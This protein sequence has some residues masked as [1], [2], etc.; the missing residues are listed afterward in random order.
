[1]HELII[2]EQ[3]AR[4]YLLSELQQDAPWTVTP[5]A[6]F[7]EHPLENEGRVTVF[8]FNASIGGN[9][10]EPF[11]VVV[12]QTVPNYYPQWGLDADQIYSVHLGTRFMLV[13]E[14]RQVPLDTLPSTLKRDT[15][16]QLE[17]IVPGEPVR[18]LEPAAVWQADEQLHVV[19]RA[20]I[21]DEDVF[22]MAADLP[23]G[24]YR[25]TQLPPHVVYRWH[26]GTVIRLEHDDATEEDQATCSRLT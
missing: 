17:G 20:T 15:L 10:E 11:Y 1:M 8:S 23:M 4:E 16:A 24:V 5:V 12:G 2:Q 18:N 7:D 21:A 13:V 19:C 6:S 25:E 14:V 26:L 22:I 9:P 3:L